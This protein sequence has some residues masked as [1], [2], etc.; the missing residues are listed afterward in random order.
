MKNPCFRLLAILLSLIFAIIGITAQAE[1]LVDLDLS[2]MSGTIVYS[3]IYNM[4]YDPEPYLGKIIRISGWYDAYMD[5]STGM[6]YTACVIPD[7]T[8]CCSQG[9]E[10]VWAGEHI[11][12]IDYPEPGADMTVTGRL[13]TYEEDGYL[14]L[15]LVDAQVEWG[16]DAEW[17]VP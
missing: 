6:V 1:M 7:A 17:V 15:H 2:Q 5:G 13:E 4:M 11:Y 16:E 8:A 14:Y 3:Q 12:P 9:I 10:F